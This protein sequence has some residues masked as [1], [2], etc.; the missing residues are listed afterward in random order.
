MR[1][2]QNRNGWSQD[3]FIK[4]NA[5]IQQLVSMGAFGPS[6][7]S[8][9]ADTNQDAALVY[10]AKAGMMLQGNWN[11]P[12][13][14]TNSPQ[15]VQSGNPGWFPF[16]AVEGGTG[17]PKNISGNPCN[18]YSIAKAAKSPQDCVTYLKSAV[19]SSD[20]VNKLIALGDVPPVQGIAVSKFAKQRVAA[21]QL[22]DGAER[23]SLPVV[24]GPGV[25]A[26][27]RRRAAY[28]S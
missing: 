6:F 23:A 25:V 8:V 22:P 20:N 10:T 19:L 28:Q 26:S 12:V 13:F 27:S 24:L 15:L 14:Q 4:A 9:I 11:F 21:I 7:A 2:K 1:T 17:D 3:A 16:P 5:A 18:Y